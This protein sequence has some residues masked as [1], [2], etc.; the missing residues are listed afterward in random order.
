MFQ[1]LQFIKNNYP[2]KLRAVAKQQRKLSLLATTILLSGIVPPN[3]PTL[4][5]DALSLQCV[6]NN[7]NPINNKV[8]SQYNEELKS[9]FGIVR[10]ISN[11]QGNSNS[12]T[13]D[14]DIK[15]VV[16]TIPQGI[17]NEAGQPI[18]TVGNFSDALTNLLISNGSNRDSART[19]ADQAIADFAN[20]L[21]A[22]PN[23]STDTVAKQVKQSLGTQGQSL[24]D[25]SIIQALTGTSQTTLLAIGL[26]NTEAINAAQAAFDKIEISANQTY[27]QALDLTNQT[28]ISIAGAKGSLIS[29]NLNRLKTEIRNIQ[30]N[31]KPTPIKT[32]DKLSFVF[33]F[34]NDGTLNAPLNLPSPSRIQNEG[35]S[36]PGSVVDVKYQIVDAQ[37][38]EKA[39]TQDT[40]I[41]L[42][43]N[44]S[45]QLTVGV[46]VGQVSSERATP[47]NVRF[48]SGCGSTEDSGDPTA[49]GS[50][51]Q[52][53]TIVPTET[54]SNVFSTS[55]QVTSCDGELFSSYSNFQVALYDLR[56]PQGIPQIGNLTNLTTT[57]FPDVAGNG[58][59]QGR[60]PNNTNKSMFV[61][62]DDGV[63]KGEYIFLLDDSQGQLDEGRTYILV[64]SPPGDRNLGERQIQIVIGK[65]QGNFVSYTATS[66]D[67]DSIRAGN[68]QQILQG[69]FALVDNTEKSGQKLAGINLRTK[70]CEAQEISIVKTGDRAAAEPGDTVIYRISVKSLIDSSIQ[71]VVVSDTLPAGFIF[72]P[73]AT[74]ATIDNQTVS[75]TAQVNGRD[76]KFTLNGTLNKGKTLN[77]IYGA[78]LTPDAVRGN[79]INSALVNGDRNDATG[80]KVKAGPSNYKVR[81]DPGILS[82]CG[83]LIGRV[84]VDKNFDGEQQ[85][86]EPGIPNAIV[87]LQDG[88]R[89]TTDANGLFSVTNV[90]PGYFTGVLDLTSVPGYT[91]APNLYFNE[92]NS[93]SRLVHLEPGGMVRMNFAVTPTFQEEAK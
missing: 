2:Q 75:V 91:L 58:I 32:G 78:Q 27:Q 61:L 67:G 85:P 26:N 83:T 79:G 4:A 6:V 54:D 15:P 49:S 69:S 52:T 7:S 19:L 34:K 88:N 92:R 14:V 9:D 35:L 42:E 21:K 30:A 23:V 72:E 73:K 48:Q 89:I 1:H 37:E 50:A 13:I 60:E 77:I 18:A 81:V 62:G 51:Q 10:G 65:R 43:K 22:E 24:N 59:P 41:T 87:Y 28:A 11:L 33:L 25:R 16:N 36:G 68:N 12:V 70:I 5:A 45:L 84:F 56:S 63:K 31:D 20:L 46:I 47:L 93:Q 64:I 80:R 3:A 74:R 66:L 44:Q 55:G 90:L 57:E 76:V 29:D 39:V 82:S 17:F 8:T 38:G 40:P 53:V 86:G 71:N